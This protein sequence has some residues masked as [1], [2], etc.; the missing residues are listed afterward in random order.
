MKFLDCNACFGKEIV[1]HECVN[2]E[3]FII[4]EPVKLANTAEELLAEMDRVEI[5]QAVVWHQSQYNYDAT[6]GN[7]NLIREIA[8][9]EDRLIP[10]W[11]ILPG[12][13]K[14]EE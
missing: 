4:L 9:N 7:E 14:G 13:G 1:N 5:S 8:G 11:V 12:Q 3:N 10:S 6:A 2:H